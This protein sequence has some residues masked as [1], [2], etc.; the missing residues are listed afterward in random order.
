MQAEL[1]FEQGQAEMD[2]GWRALRGGTEKPV[3][4]PRQS[5]RG[6]R[7]GKDSSRNPSIGRTDQG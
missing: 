6:S 3:E 7:S 5:A 1:L 2:A 4:T